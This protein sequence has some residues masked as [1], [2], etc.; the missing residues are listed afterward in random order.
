M[1]RGSPSRP[2]VLITASMSGLEACTMK[3]PFA[4]PASNQ[5]QRKIL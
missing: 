1:T 4:T 5:L 3:E 2:A